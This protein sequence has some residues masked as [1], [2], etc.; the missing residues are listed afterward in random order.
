M[1]FFEK[2][3]VIKIAEDDLKDAKLSSMDYSDDSV[4]KRAFIDVLGARLAMKLL[5]SQKIE[6]NNIYSLYTIHNVLE[7][8]DLSDIYYQGIKIDV[9]LVFDKNEIFIPRKHFE[10]DLLPDL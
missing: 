5:F 7:E 8:L 4:K 1:K 2:K 3:S 10:F 6:A 9:R